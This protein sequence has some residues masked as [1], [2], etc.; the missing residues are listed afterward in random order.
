MYADY[1]VNVSPRGEQQDWKAALARVL[2]DVE[3][4]MSTVEHKCRTQEV[5]LRQTKKRT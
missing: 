1:C 5:T 2:K 3:I 4:E